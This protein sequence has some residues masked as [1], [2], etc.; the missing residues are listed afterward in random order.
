MNAVE[1]INSRLDVE[2]V[3]EHFEFEHISHNGKFLRS[4]CKLH[5]GD[6]PSG[7]VIDSE[8]GL[9]FCHTGGCG[10]GDIFRLVEQLMEID[11]KHAVKWLADF[12]NIDISQLKLE[13]R[14]KQQEQE[15]KRWVQ[16]IKSRKKEKLKPHTIDVPLR[17]VTKFRNFHESTLK[18]FGVGYVESVQ[19]EKNVKLGEEPSYYTLQHRLY[20]PIIQGNQ[21]IGYSLRK[22]KEADFPKWTHQ[23]KGIE[24]GNLLYNYDSSLGVREIVVVEGAFDVWAYHEIGIPAVATYGAH[25]THEQYKM[26]MRTGADIT[27]SFDGDEAGQKATQKGIELFRNKADINIVEFLSTED[28]ASISREELR[29]RYDERRKV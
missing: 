29:K 14:N 13:E 24:V 16:A 1:M 22:T 8:T 2:R 7:F 27:L 4:C 9:Y 17:E 12:L 10:G 19:L 18:H 20:L 21:T 28:P 6:N 23:P 15:L 25:I 26:L 11:F 3:L 5:G